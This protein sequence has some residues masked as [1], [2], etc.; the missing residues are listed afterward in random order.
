M[1]LH[2]GSL[3]LHGLYPQ[4]F[5]AILLAN[6]SRKFINKRKKEKE[7]KSSSITVINCSCVIRKLSTER[8][9]NNR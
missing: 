9:A 8:R 6:A 1:T 2:S 3:S 5:H 4:Q 7:E